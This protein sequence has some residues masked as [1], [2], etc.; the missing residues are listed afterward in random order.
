MLFRCLASFRR[1]M[2]ALIL[3]LS[4]GISIDIGVHSM[5]HAAWIIKM[6]MLYL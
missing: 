3:A 4:I 6:C 2:S 1:D 5:Q